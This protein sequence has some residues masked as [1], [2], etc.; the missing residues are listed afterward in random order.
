MTNYASSYKWRGFLV[1]FVLTAVALVIWFWTQSLIARRALP[2]SGV[3]DA[4]HTLTAGLNAYFYSSPSAANALLIL[5]SA[6]IDGLGLFLLARWLFGPSVRP[7]L[8]L[9]AL[10]GM[11][12]IMQAICALPPPPNMIWH[13]PGFPSLLVTYNVGNDFFFSGH[14]AI[15]VFGGI[16]LARIGKRWLT[17]MAVV[18]VIFEIAAVL[19]LRA[20]YTMD[21]FTGL[22]AALCVA[23]FCDKVAPR[24]DAWLSPAQ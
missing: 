11:R 21:V 9:V 7:F 4:L 5:S 14:T 19:I 12:Q 6:L 20:H 18:V 8:G 17:I 15:A 23:Q 10:L 2:P 22:L 3:G 24:L 13:Y 1:R 16:E